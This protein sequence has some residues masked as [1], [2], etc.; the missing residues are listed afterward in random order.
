MGPGAGARGCGVATGK[1]ASKS[2]GGKVKVGF[3]YSAAY[4]VDQ[5]HRSH[6]FGSG[7]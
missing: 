6:K 3:L 4:M 5:E 1:L 7:T 2:E